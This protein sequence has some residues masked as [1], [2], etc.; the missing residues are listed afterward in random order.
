MPG[1]TLE[2]GQ[3][4]FPFSVALPDWLPA[5]MAFACYRESGHLSISY[6]LTAQF[7]AQESFGDHTF[8]NRKAI[9]VYRP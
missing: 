9:H 8:L 4:S 3:Y 2:P 1:E 6:S 7:V 5:S